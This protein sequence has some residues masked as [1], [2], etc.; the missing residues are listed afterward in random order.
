MAIDQ[1]EAQFVLVEIKNNNI[2]SHVK[3]I[4]YHDYLKVLPMLLLCLD[5]SI[6]TMGSQRVQGP[7]A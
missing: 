1:K 2:L 3:I 5:I 6:K 4:E 7:V